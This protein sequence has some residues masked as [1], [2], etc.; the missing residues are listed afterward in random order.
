[1]K[2]IPEPEFMCD[3]KQASAY[4]RAD[5]EAPHSNFI[6]LLKLTTNTK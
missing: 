6:D 5:F 2:R 1:M 3:K 4:A